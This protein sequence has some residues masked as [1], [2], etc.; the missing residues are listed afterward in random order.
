MK[1][2]ELRKEVD[3]FST[4]LEGFIISASTPPAGSLGAIRDRIKAIY[5]E[6]LK[7]DAIS[8]Y[9][10][11]DKHIVCMCITRALLLVKILSSEIDINMGLNV[12]QRNLKPSISELNSKEILVEAVYLYILKNKHSQGMIEVVRMLKKKVQIKQIITN[13]ESEIDLFMLSQ[14][15]KIVEAKAKELLPITPSATNNDLI[16][17]LNIVLEANS[18]KYIEDILLNNVHPPIDI[19]SILRQLILIE[20][21]EIS[22]QT[23]EVYHLVLQLL[24]KYIELKK[25]K[26]L[27][28]SKYVV[29]EVLDDDCV[30]IMVRILEKENIP[31][32][33]R[34]EI[35][36]IL[37][38]SDIQTINYTHIPVNNSNLIPFI[39]YIVKNSDHVDLL[40]EILEVLE[41]EITE[42]G[43][44]AEVSN[45]I[46]IMDFL[47]IILHTYSNSMIAADN[48]TGAM[49][50]GLPAG[51]E[52][53]NSVQAAI[54]NS[55]SLEKYIGNSIVEVYNNIIP[56]FTNPLIIYN[57]LTIFT[58]LIRGNGMSDATTH[59]YGA[60]NNRNSLMGHSI[61]ALSIILKRISAYI[62]QGDM[63]YTEMQAVKLHDLNSPYSSV[64]TE[65]S[66]RGKDIMLESV[67]M[68]FAIII[69]LPEQIKSTIQTSYVLNIVFRVVSK[70]SSPV[71]DDVIA[72]IRGFF[73]SSTLY[74]LATSIGS[75]LYSFISILISKGELDTVYSLIQN[76]NKL[77]KGILHKDILSEEVLTE[78]KDKNVLYSIL[79]TI[80]VQYYTDNSAL[81]N[82]SINKKIL[83]IHSTV[84]S[85]IK[86][87]VQMSELLEESREFG[88]FFKILCVVGKTLG[89]EC[90]DMLDAMLSKTGNSTASAAQCQ[91]SLLYNSRSRNISEL[92]YFYHFVYRGVDVKTKLS[93]KELGAGRDKGL[94]CITELHNTYSSNT[95]KYLALLGL[96]GCDVKDKQHIKMY[97]DLDMATL[98]ANERVLFVNQ[99][100]R[101]LFLSGLIQSGEHFISNPLNDPSFNSVNGAMKEEKEKEKTTDGKG[102]T[103]HQGTL[104]KYA[105]M[106]IRSA[107]KATQD[108]GIPHTLPHG[109]LAAGEPWLVSALLY[110]LYDKSP[111]SSLVLSYIKKMRKYTKNDNTVYSRVLATVIL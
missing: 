65:E 84:L 101:G 13:T 94:L 88:Y 97:K 55:I 30:G 73:T 58:Q 53:M 41:I 6:V 29:Y 44:E 5:D 80:I 108:T 35:M 89:L 92:Y 95:L 75:N 52:R 102:Q 22:G 20:S 48:L 90:S 33:I 76:S 24:S 81:N 67:K 54:N 68:L 17:A 47:N 106:S 83:D 23:L 39:R 63:I 79:S 50:A 16:I 100:Y 42:E 51:N 57:Y 61:N 34:S 38:A 14:V 18:I 74:K 109:I 77:Y 60:I 8:E 25:K 64:C 10:I 12:L 82:S 46:V 27:I 86:K 87:P 4:K 111:N 69:S 104:Y 37:V 85:N 28:N 99:I 31:G 11:I 103:L 9:L 36:D 59:Y 1:F 91:I 43:N 15:E 40:L 32:N 93:Q 110:T 62:V 72:F 3:S 107:I 7:L 26:D 56:V 70:D 78:H 21:V 71:S 105:D 98:S 49:G 45:L 19:R 96:E 2:Y 66:G